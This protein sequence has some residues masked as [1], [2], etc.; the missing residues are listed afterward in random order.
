MLRTTLAIGAVALTAGFA[1]AENPK[2]LHDSR[3]PGGYVGPAMSPV[4]ASYTLTFEDLS[5]GDTLSNQY[6]AQGVTFTTD[7][8]W[9][10]G[11]DMT[12]VASSGSDVGG[13]GTPALVSGNIIHSFDGWLSESDDANVLATFSTPVSSVSVDFAG[14]ANSNFTGLAIFDVN[15]DLIDQSFVTASTGQHTVSLSSSTD[16]YYVGVFPGEFN[17]WVGW[18][19]FSYTQVNIPEPT[20]LGALAAIGA[21]ALRRRSK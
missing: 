1:F 20:T 14:V 5:V 2:L 19:N 12:V 3:S 4:E 9:A 15:Q 13:L 21:V 16:I 10:A 6:A 11:T 7:E 17:D 18:D 8:F